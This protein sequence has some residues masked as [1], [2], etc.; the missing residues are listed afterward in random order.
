MPNSAAQ[1]PKPKRKKSATY[2][3]AAFDAFRYRLNEYVKN[4]YVT[5]E[6]EHRLSTHPLK[7]DIIVIK[8]NRDVEIDTPWGKI[9]RDCNIVEYKSPVSPP[10][11][12]S[13][14]TKVVYGYAGV[15]SS[16]NDIKLTDMSA[17]IM[18]PKKPTDLFETLKNE[19]NYR[20]LRKGRG[21]YYIVQRGCAPEK[22][23]AV[24]VVVYS[25]LEDSD[26]VLKALKPGIDG[27]MARKVLEFPVDNEESIP[28]LSHWWDVMWLENFE[29]L[30][31]EVNMNK[32]DKAVKF[33]KDN[34]LLT[35]ILQEE[36][37]A[38]VLERTTQLL[39]YLKSGHSIEEAEKEF[40]LR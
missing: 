14:F 23:L 25:E 24:Q 21:I 35:E 10:L 11:T 8:K 40:A 19:F 4:G 1:A 6:G 30:T 37:Q 36:R 5:L 22:S 39:E 9:F 20:V 34:G 16:Q 26:L 15:Y 31:L 29:I 33:M 32:R 12:L 27:A 18:Y 3:D 38:G 2:H 28:L 7:I 13:V 17:T